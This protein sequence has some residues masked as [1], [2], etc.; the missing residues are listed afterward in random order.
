[1][2]HF[3]SIGLPGLAQL[4]YFK[5]RARMASL[6]WD[7]QLAERYRRLQYEF[8]EH[9]LKGRVIV[10]AGGAGG[11]GAATA[12]LLAREGARL[13]IG[14]RSDRERASALC[15]ALERVGGP[16][17]QLVEG[18]LTEASVRREYFNA[19]AKT[20]GLLYGVAIFAGDPARVPFESLDRE[21]MEASLRT[22]YVGPILL[23]KELGS[24]VE[25]A[26]S[27]GSV[28]LLGTMQALAP[29][30]SSLNYGPAKA[31]L[32]QAARILAKQWTRVRVNV[33]APGT[34]VAGMA[35]SSVQAGKYDIFRKSG[36]ISRF[37][38]PE[39]IARAV[40][41]LLEPDNY[42]TGQVLVVDGGLTLRRDQG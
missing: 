33:V 4:G 26:G 13:V 34:T 18:D 24:A 30:A 32:V 12:V 19:A 16:P 28:V 1:M 22:N 31:A 40:R 23:A 9:P 5:R 29:F 11:L 14:Y 7:E 20:G 27:D 36:A 2:L 21:P 37:G 8:P 41:F 38:R 35:A 3:R 17:P 25:Q 6:Y 15:K 42:T 39:D 10:L